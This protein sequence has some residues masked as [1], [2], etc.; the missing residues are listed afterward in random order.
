MKKG[1][2][3]KNREKWVVGPNMEKLIFEICDLTGAREHL[4]PHQCALHIKGHLGR[5]IAVCEEGLQMF[6][7]EGYGPDKEEEAREHF[8]DE[9]IQPWTWLNKLREALKGYT[10]PFRNLRAK[11]HNAFT[12]ID[13]L[14]EENPSLIT[15][16]VGNKTL[17][18]VREELK[19]ELGIGD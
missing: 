10:D 8:P 7:H 17:G 9:D 1:L 2:S 11:A 13:T 5:L 3:V 6:E 12:A 4:D 18:N 19:A 14:L 16:M 15:K